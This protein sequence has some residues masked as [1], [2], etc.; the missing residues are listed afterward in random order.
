[1]VLPG[2]AP[3]RNETSSSPTPPRPTTMLQHPSR[4]ITSRT[5]TLRD[6][7]ACHSPEFFSAPAAWFDPRQDLFCFSSSLFSLAAF[8][9]AGHLLAKVISCS[10]QSPIRRTELNQIVVNSILS[11]DKDGDRRI[12]YGAALCMEKRR[13]LFKLLLFLLL[14]D[15][16]EEQQIP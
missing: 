9:S 2:E 6:F 16:R 3:L 8:Y 14:S 4:R 12:H 10:R 5:R 1:M 13:K 7:F 15:G 11:L